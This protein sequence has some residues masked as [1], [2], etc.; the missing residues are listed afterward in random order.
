MQPQLPTA[1]VLH[2][3]WH[4][5]AHRDV[6]RRKSSAGLPAELVLD[7]FLNGSWLSTE[8]TVLTYASDCEV[9]GQNQNK[10]ISMQKLCRLPH[11]YYLVL[12][13]LRVTH[14][15]QD[16]RRCRRSQASAHCQRNIN[17]GAE[18]LQVNRS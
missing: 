13:D 2:N 6:W 5:S 17:T 18:G 11:E 4:D 7:T 3:K 14:Q 8:H 1:L 15:F 16:A 10:G 9:S 12:P